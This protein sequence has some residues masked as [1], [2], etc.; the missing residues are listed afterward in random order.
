MN[1]H[2]DI[3]GT[4]GSQ[5]NITLATPHGA[6]HLN[7]VMAAHDQ[8]TM[9]AAELHAFL[10]LVNNEEGQDSFNGMNR[11]LRSSLLWMASRNAAGLVEL[12]EKVTFAGR[13]GNNA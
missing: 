8:A 4:N 7:D 13:G 6:L 1:G 11:E 12:L 9:M 5:L 10:V 3:S 2:N